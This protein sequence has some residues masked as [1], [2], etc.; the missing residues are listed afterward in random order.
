MQHVLIDDKHAGWLSVTSGV[1]QGSLLGPALFSLFINDMPRALSHSSTLALFADDAKCFHTIRAV[2]DCEWSDE[3]KLVFNSDKCSLCSVT[4]KRGPITYDFTMGTK[5]LIRVY[6]QL[7]LGV[8]ITCDTRFNE[9]IYAQVNKA[10]KMLGSIHRTISISEQYLPTLRSLYTALVR[11]HLD[12]AS[13]IWSPRSISMTK[14][15]EVVQRRATRVL[16][17]KLSYNERLERLDLLLLFSL[18][19]RSQRP[20]SFLQTQVWSL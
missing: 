13:E 18:P 3:G 4:R 1:P 2:S 15:V 9:R 5:T 6:T 12:Y 20:C 16:L 14:L 19:K 10:N 11:S 8:L 7:G 17:P